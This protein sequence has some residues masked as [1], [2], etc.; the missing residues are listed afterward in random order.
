MWSNICIK[1][2]DFFPRA[3]KEKCYTCANF[4]KIHRLERA[5]YAFLDHSK[6]FVFRDVIKIEILQIT[7]LRMFSLRFLQTCQW[8]ISR[9]V[10]AYLSPLR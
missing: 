10:E 7:V 4:Q 5:Q 1:F 6:T 3:G 2:D 8:K 9:E